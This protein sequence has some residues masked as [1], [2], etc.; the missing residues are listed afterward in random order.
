MGL[1]GESES[2]D[3]HLSDF[4]IVL[5]KIMTSPLLYFGSQSFMQFVKVLFLKY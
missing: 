1:A 2:I 5:I 4:Q 3:S